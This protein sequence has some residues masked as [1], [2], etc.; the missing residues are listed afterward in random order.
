[1]LLGLATVVMVNWALAALLPNV[2]VTVV[3][4]NGVPAFGIGVNSVFEA[5]PPE[6][7][8]VVV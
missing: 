5:W 7:V 1:M 3:W 6:S 4:T 2:A 8:V